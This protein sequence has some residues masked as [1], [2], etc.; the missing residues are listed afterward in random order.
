MSIRCYLHTM[1]TLTL[2]FCCSKEMYSRAHVHKS[3]INSV[4]KQ[5]LLS[6]FSS[7]VLPPFILHPFPLPPSLSSINK[8]K[9]IGDIICLNNYCPLTLT[10]RRRRRF[11]S[12][13]IF[14]QSSLPRL[15]VLW[16]GFRTKRDIP[17]K[18]CF[19]YCYS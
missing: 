2:P 6:I 18:K 10:V 4:L 8:F 19:F 17:F 12:R 16:W 1:I 11:P 14:Y 3:F 9:D 13:I 15:S 7:P 5:Y